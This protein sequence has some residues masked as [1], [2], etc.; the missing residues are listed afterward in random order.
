[1]KSLRGDRK[2]QAFKVI[3]PIL[4]YFVEVQMVSFQGYLVKMF[5]LCTV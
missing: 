5:R 4:G 3:I 2:V 1:M